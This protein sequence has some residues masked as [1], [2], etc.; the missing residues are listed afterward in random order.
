MSNIVKQI[1]SLN[2]TGNVIPNRWW[3]QITFESGKPDSVAVVLL[4]EIVYWYR[5]TERRCEETGLTTGYDKKFRSDMLQRSY[6]SFS[7]Q[8]GYTKRQ[9]TEAMKR[10]KEKGLVNMEFR[11]IVVNGTPVNNVLYLAPVPEKIREITFGKDHASTLSRSN[12][13]GGTLERSPLPHSNVTAPTLERETNT[14]IT[15]EITT[16]TTSKDITREKREKS[17]AK[18]QADQMDKYDLSSWPE[19]PSQQVWDDWVKQRKK[20]RALISPTVISRFGKQLHLAKQHGF[21]VDDCLAEC[22]V[23]G[24]RGFEAEWMLNA[25]NRKPEKAGYMSQSTKPDYSKGIG[26]DGRF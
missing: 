23:R 7:E 11:T 1:T 8:F 15:E 24:W 26:P 21:S 14:E 16:E 19:K 2:I 9:V 22:I 12:G 4:S 10:L 5:A 13:T 18:K 17:S 3:K 6:Q 25:H 20:V